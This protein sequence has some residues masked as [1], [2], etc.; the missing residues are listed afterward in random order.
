M[1]AQAKLLITALA[2]GGSISTASAAGV[3]TDITASGGGLGS[4]EVL[5]NTTDPN[6][7]DLS[8]TFDSLDPIVLTF[9]VGHIDGGPGNPYAVTETI[10][11]NTGQSWV[12]FHFS[13]TEPTTGG[14]GVVFTNFSNSELTGFTL[15]SPSSG[16]TGPRNLNFTGELADQGMATATFNLSPFD[17]GAGNTAT[18]TLTQ[19]PTIPEPETYAMLLAGL[20]LVG[21]MARRRSSK[22]NA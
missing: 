5:S 14:Q 19:V 1:N 17:P 21:A 20:G 7:L 13:I 8:K 9:T 4:F 2:F 10:T 3:I 18:F 12:D 6:V 15:D 16:S 22:R 11:N